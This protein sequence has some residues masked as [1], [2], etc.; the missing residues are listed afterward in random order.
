MNK[1]NIEL[2]QRGEELAANFL[3]RKGYKLLQRNYRS[4]F[5]QIDIIAK[6]K[7]YFCFIEVK[8]RKSSLYGLP[9]EAVS[10]FKQRRIARTALTYLKENRLIKTRARFDVISIL[11]D[12]GSSDIELIKNAFDLEDRYAY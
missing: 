7:K 10:K 1:D 8:T 5:G 9:K 12:R 4:R 11:L 6:E 2:G 3:Q